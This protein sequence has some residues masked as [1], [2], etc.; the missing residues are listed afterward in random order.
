LD[1]LQRFLEQYKPKKT[2]D[3]YL[4]PGRWGRGHLHVDFASIILRKA[5]EQVDIIGASTHS[6]RG[7]ARTALTQMS[8]AGILLRII[9]EI[10]GQR[11][12]DQLQRYL[13]VEHEQVKGALASLS[14]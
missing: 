8:N 12:L 14:L 11:N 5:C 9:Q 1:D 7:T 10:S 6:F 4:F 2:D 13:E 3:G